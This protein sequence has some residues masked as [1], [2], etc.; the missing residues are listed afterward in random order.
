[1]KVIYLALAG[2]DQ[3][4]EKNKKAQEETWAGPDSLFDIFWVYGN[5]N[6]GESELNGRN[7]TVPVAE[8]YSNLLLKTQLAMDWLVKNTEYDYV[9][10]TNTS[11]YF[12]HIQVLKNLSLKDK[13]E[14]AVGGFQGEWLGTISGV[15][16]NY[17]YVSGA[18]II[19]SREATEKLCLL[20]YEEYDSVPDDVAI[21]HY[22]KKFDFQFFT[23]TRCD[24]TDYEMVKPAQQYRV[25][26]WTS[27]EITCLR[28]HELHRIQ[29]A[30]G[31]MRL[32][33]AIIRHA[34]NEVK[35][36]LNERHYMRKRIIFTHIFAIPV[37]VFQFAKINK[38]IQRE[39]RNSRT[40]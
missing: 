16:S 21:T 5:E 28:M 7:L 34:I 27:S 3:I 11:N 36:C 18:G 10:R 13:R 35:R 26:H 19:L 17:D 37:S 20:P 4:H 33:S 39:L 31:P 12:N 25:K 38:T 30:L 24:T 22:L 1:M 40:N 32:L 6:Q 2:G 9:I 23:T 15:F 29:L 8:E 14:K